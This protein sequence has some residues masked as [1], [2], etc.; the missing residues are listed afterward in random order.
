MVKN[1]INNHHSKKSQYDERI[2]VY[3]S[4]LK[5]YAKD[6]YL[7]DNMSDLTMFGKMSW[8]EIKGKVCKNKAYLKQSW[9]KDLSSED[10][11]LIEVLK[12]IQTEIGVKEPLK[13][14]KNPIR[15]RQIEERID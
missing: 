14:C 6:F 13:P 7:Q 1:Q 12:V 8:E 11:E 5:T 9:Y 10:K 2:N 4:E 3:L 15:E